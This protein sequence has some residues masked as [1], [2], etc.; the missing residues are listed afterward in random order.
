M[1]PK[2]KAIKIFARFNAETAMQQPYE[3][4]THMEKEKQSAL[5]CVEEIEKE[6]GFTFLYGD[7]RRVFL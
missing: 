6:L 7:K 1:T 2:G 5:I 3:H 4:K